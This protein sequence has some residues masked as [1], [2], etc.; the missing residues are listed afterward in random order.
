MIKFEVSMNLFH[1]LS[2][3]CRKMHLLQAFFDILHHF[4]ANTKEYKST[5]FYLSIRMRTSL[6]LNSLEYSYA[7]AVF[8]YS[9]TILI[10]YLC[11]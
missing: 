3:L 2:F 1:V 4:M 9:S 10:I 8:D 11:M 5:S 7:E 6:L